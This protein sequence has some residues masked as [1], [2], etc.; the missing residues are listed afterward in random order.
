MKS[1]GSSIGRLFTLC[2]LVVLLCRVH[3]QTVTASDATSPDTA[4]VNW[5]TASD[6]Q[7]MLQAVEQT[8]P[9]PASAVPHFGTFYSAQHAPGGANQW[10]PLPANVRGVNVWDLGGNFYLLDDRTVNYS[11]RQVKTASKGGTMMAM[12]VLVPGSGGG[13]GGSDGNF[14]T[15]LVQP[16]YGTNLWLEITNSMNNQIAGLIHNSSPLVPYALLSKQSLTWPAWNPAAV[17]YGSGFTTNITQ[18]KVP[19]L[20]RGSLF[21]QARARF[22][23]GIIG[24]G[25]SHNVV[26]RRDGTVW[27]WGANGSGQLG[28]GQWSDSTTPVQVAGLSNIVALSVAPDDSFTLAL[29][30]QGKVWSWGANAFGQLGRGDGLYADANN[31][32]IVPGI[33]NIV[34]IAGGGGHA[35]VLRGDGT[36]WAWGG[37]DYGDLGDNSGSVRDF[38]APVPGLTNVIGI[39]SGVY[40]NLALCAD[41]RV[42]GWGLNEFAELGIGNEDDQPQPVLVS[43]LTNAVALS[44]GFFHSVALL[45]DGTVM[46]WGDNFEGEIG[47][48]SSLTPVPVS[49]LSNI[50]AIACGSVHNLFLDQNGRLFVWGNAGFGEL[51]GADTD[52]TTP[53]L[54]TSVSNVT[55]IAGG[56]DSSMISTA[57]GSIYVWGSSGSGQQSTPFLVNLYANY[58][59][60]GSGMSDWWELEYFGHLG[61][62]P[63]AD[64]DGDGW[65]ILQEYQNG[66]NPTN[67]DTP[68]AVAGLTATQNTNSTVVTLTWNAETPTPTN[69]VIYRTDYNYGTWQYGS[70][71][72]IGEVAGN[73]TSFV[74]NGNVSGGDGNSIYAVE[75]VYSGGTSPLSGQVYIDSITPPALVPSQPLTVQLVRNGT[76]R[77]QL[78]FGNLPSDVQTIRLY[79]NGTAQD[80]SPS[81]LNNGIYQI[82]DADV[83][84]VLGDAVSV[85]TIATNGTTSATVQAG[86]IANDAPYFVDGRQHMKQNLNFLIRGAP[87]YKTFGTFGNFPQ[88]SSQTNFEFSSFLLPS[89]LDNLWP[90]KENYSLANYIADT[91]RTETTWAGSA[92]FGT[93][94]FDFQINFSTNIPAPPILAHSDPYWIIQRQ[95]TFGIGYGW[96]QPLDWDPISCG[97][98]ETNYVGSAPTTVSF[99]T[100]IQNVFGLPYETGLMVQEGYAGFPLVYAP[101]DPGDTISAMY[102]PTNGY[103]FSSYASWCPTPTLEFTNYFF[104]PFANPDANSMN[105]LLYNQ[106]VVAPVNGQFAA[107]NQ[108]SVVMFGSVGQPMILGAWAKYS[109]SNSSPTK[110]AYLGQYFTTNAFKVDNDGNLTSTNT[111]IVSPY[112]EFF[113]TEPGPVA[114]I[115]MPDIDTGMQATGIVHVISLALDA[116]HDGTIDTTFNGPDFVSANHPFRFWVNNNYDR[117]DLDT[118]DGISEQD[119]VQAGDNSDSG[120]NFDP[121]DPDYDYKDLGGNRTI[122]C[123]RDLEDFARLW[124]C[125]FDSI[126]SSNLPYGSTATLSWGDVGNANP[127]NPTIDVFQAVEGYGGIG[128]LTN[129]TTAAEQIDPALNLYVGRIKPGQGI[130]MPAQLLGSGY[131]MHHLIWCGVTNGTGRL[132]LTIADAHSNVLAQASTYIQLVDIKQMYERWTV[133]DNSS[134]LPNSFAEIATN[135][136]PVGVR[137][138][139]FANPGDTGTPYIIFVHGYALETWEKDRFAETA[140][141]RLYWQGYQGRFGTFRWPTDSNPLFFDSSELQGWNSALGLRNKLFALNAQYPG[142][143]YLLAH[144]LGNIVAGEALRLMGTNLVVN[145]Y[146]AAQGAV[147]AHTYDSTTPTRSLGA[148]ELGMPNCYAQYWTNGAT[149][150][151]HGNAGARAYVNFFNTNDWALDVAWQPDQNLKPDALFGY[152][153]VAP[154]NYFNSSRQLFFPGDTYELFARVIQARCYAIGAQA[155]VKGAF[156]KNGTPLQVNLPDVW[157]P[158][159]LNN[160]YKAHIWHSAEFRSDNAQRWQFWDSV[161]ATFGITRQ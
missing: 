84:N 159:P 33:S 50:I 20:S 5:T 105:I 26:I 151:F 82:P 132:T 61:V 114:L 71:Q 15:G 110:Y 101:I 120:Q 146:I 107:T 13:S 67:F 153:F 142:N 147:A 12:D 16:N 158:D 160:N 92:L 161:L 99:L 23:P 149:S 64:P 11:A 87:R 68:P 69:Y 94:N 66:T 137:P 138:F 140:F 152:G 91:T 22:A 19:A 126:L 135:D 143:V 1:I 89:W 53:F 52:P 29:D 46:A 34:A 45:A 98:L 8:T 25:A 54:L 102:D 104:A 81:S 113:P 31:A 118:I 112:G 119:D 141:K 85:E 79:W 72:Q 96:P 73:I 14:N 63:N 59:S 74:D 148:Y 51:T 58:S 39:V 30:S 88:S 17:F 111:G 77:W 47:N 56:E 122:P 78:M 2:M 145:T 93:T 127:A 144:S 60:D 124:I 129:E 43:T 86:T 76:G 32:A 128:Y 121:N 57:D 109:I 154:T 80:I 4:T 40:H 150:Y 131:N 115:T 134:Q 21:V 97:I 83:V 27:A 3:A 130:Q 37:N 6:L 108:T 100:G 36:V 9:L 44:G 90:F 10:P 156:Q 95:C 75:A 35:V 103:G 18:F 125:G 48:L 123:T 157:P 155:D 116:N 62:N 42:W 24:A 65:S 28:N 139:Q 38:A 136:L 41:G 133:G 7:V 106:N 70:A 49:G 55:T 117:W